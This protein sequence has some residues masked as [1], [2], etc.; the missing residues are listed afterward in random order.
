M[1]TSAGSES[2][3]FECAIPWLLVPD[4]ERT[5]Q[6]Y[7]LTLGFRRNFLST[8]EGI[9][10]VYRDLAML[11]FALGGGE[12]RQNTHSWRAQIE[13]IDAA[14]HVHGLAAIFDDVKNRGADLAGPIRILPSGLSYFRVRDCNG[15]WLRF[16]QPYA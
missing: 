5:V 15:Y 3:K 12:P 7:E 9:A 11:H 16:T 4:L 13:P 8:E 1:E 2:P 14:I 10:G 6:Y